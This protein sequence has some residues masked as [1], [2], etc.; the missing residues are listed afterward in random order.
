MTN[1]AMIVSKIDKTHALVSQRGGWGSVYQCYNEL[2]N[3]YTHLGKEYP[4]PKTGAGK[5]KFSFFKRDSDI[6]GGAF[7]RDEGALP[8]GIDVISWY[9]GVDKSRAMDIIIDICGGDT[10]KVTAKDMQKL[11]EKRQTASECPISEKDAAQRSKT[12]RTTWSGLKPIAGSLAETYL[13]SRG[14]QGDAR[15]WRDVYF[16]PSLPYKEDDKAP[17]QRLPG[18]VSMVRNHDGQPVTLHRTFLSSDGTAKA[19]VSRQK[20]M[21]AQP[22]PLNGACIMLDAPTMTPTGK[23][24]GITEGIENALSIREATGCPMWVGI[25]DRIMEKMIFSEDISTIIVWADVEPSGAGMRAAET[26]RSIWETK[27]KQVV[28]QAP[29]FMG[30]E[31]CDWND[32]YV[33]KGV[34]GFDMRVAQNYRVYTGVEIPA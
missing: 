2:Y 8:D 33:E 18:M 16:H 11:K 5:T 1:T 19:N 31:K 34:A 21:L 32:V 25:S 27:G 23:M 6:R 29:H 14:M 15:S 17:W 9:E 3:A 20:M 13:R 30:R 4:C 28:I 10:T 12:L 22:K 7:H 26:L 24:I